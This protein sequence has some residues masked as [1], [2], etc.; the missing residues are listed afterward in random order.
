M[1]NLKTDNSEWNRAKIKDVASVVSGYGFPLSLQGKTSGDYPFIKVRDISETVQ[2]GKTHITSANHYIDTTE[3]NSI[4]AKPF[5]AGTVVFAKI[6]EAIKLNRRAILSQATVADNNVMGIEPNKDKLTSDYLLYFLNTIELEDI[7]HSTTVPSIRKGD[8]ENIDIIFPDIETQQL[9]TK[10]L[11]NLLNKTAASA[12]GIKKSKILIHQFKQAILSAAVTGKL[13]EEWR[14]KNNEEIQNNI[15]EVISENINKNNKMSKKSRI[16]TKTTYEVHEFEIDVDLPSNWVLENLGNI[17]ELV[18]DGEHATPIRV[19]SGIYLLSARNV[20][21][22]YLSLDKVDY[23]PESEYERIIKRCNPEEGDVLISC[24]G[25]VGRVCVVPKGIRFT[26]V[27]SAALVKMQ[28]NR[29]LSEY[30]SYYLQSQLA[31]NQIFKLQKATAQA[32]LFIGQIKKIVVVLP[33]IEE[34][35]L[36]VEKVRHYFEVANRVEKQ[37]E[38]AEARVSKLAQ[39]ILAKTFN[40]E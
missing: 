22:G 6:G 18:T 32:N 25:S 29:F 40:Q 12:N 1:Q 16:H 8:V 24:S 36:I 27:R 38:K 30:L 26:M 10:S 9:I 35:R 28:A 39:A 14:D 5:S 21:N 37:I 3:L 7:S 15:I 20:Q 19:E 31:Q 34:Q 33:P 17:S 4:K 2:Q 11:K 23:I 13:T